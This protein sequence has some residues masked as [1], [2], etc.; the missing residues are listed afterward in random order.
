MSPG[1]LGRPPQTPLEFVKRLEELRRVLSDL[2]A[3]SQLAYKACYEP[4]GHGIAQIGGHGDAVSDPTGDVAADERREMLRRTLDK[5]YR[6]IDHAAAE[7]VKLSGDIGYGLG[8][9]KRSFDARELE[10]TE[11]RRR[12]GRVH[13]EH[14][15]RAGQARASEAVRDDRGR[16]VPVQRNPQ[17]PA[18]S[19]KD[20]Q[21]RRS[22]A[23]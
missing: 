22:E 1:K 11:R 7:L 2:R 23:V 15:A 10:A 13:T 21:N 8:T 12:A 5:A 20:R 3:P 6:T 9:R 16:F 18:P 14:T 17:G 4:A 19:V